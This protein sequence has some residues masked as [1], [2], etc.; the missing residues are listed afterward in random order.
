MKKTIIL[1]FLSLFTYGAIHA[2]VTWK[3][4]GDGTLTISGTEMD[5][6]EASGAPWSFQYKKIKKVVI[7]DGV[8]NIGENAFYFCEN[9]TSVTIPNSVVNIGNS[10]FLYC[11]SLASI[12]IPNSVTTIGKWAFYGCSSL[13]SITIPKSVTTIG[14]NVFIYCKN[15]NSIK[16]EQG[17][18]RYDSRNDCNAIIETKYN[19]LIAGC[20][21]T[22]IPNSVTIV[23][24][25]AFVG[26]S[27]LTSITIP[28]SVTNIAG[29]AF[30]KC[31][32]L[33]SIKVE[34]GNVKYDSRNDCNA[35]IETKSNTL[36][37]GCKNTIIPNSV[38]S[39][40]G[41]AFDGCTDLTSITIPNSVKSIGS[42]AFNECTNLASI[43]IPK[44]VINIGDCAFQKCLG[45]TSIN[46]E[47]GNARY[48]SRNDCNAIIETETNT[49]IL[50]CKN[51]IIPNNVKGIGQ[52]AFWGCPELTSILIPN[53]V[54]VIEPGAF[55]SC[56]NLSSVS[57]PNSVIS[58]G[59]S[60]FY[61]CVSLFSFTLPSSVQSIGP[62][63]FL[64]SIRLKN[65]TCYATTPPS[66]GEG[67]FRG[68]QCENGILYVPASSVSAYQNASGWQEWGQILP[69]EDNAATSIDGIVNGQ[70]C[71][72]KIYN[73]NGQRINGY[74]THKGIY[75]KKGKKYTR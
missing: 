61:G 31:S 55:S 34:E 75:I 2:D 22:V 62:N 7:K 3:L 74:D 51:T 19:R 72:E 1:F 60:A 15:L 47:K 73:Q 46:V 54:T 32:G 59:Q 53:S 5:D 39:I 45:L 70:P 35:I 26:L 23:W 18:A 24:P 44:S 10:A 67:A 4:S 42:L 36:I 25:G 43:T 69:I 33:A 68:T 57:I 6:Y 37:S 63:A 56:R 20:N 52:N 8:T 40:L 12:T 16:V 71:D 11:S 58:I 50:G 48:D 9:I 41:S 21:N 64:S 30:S 49:L 65:M 17:N 13:T 66:V 38:T 28:K 14:D 27:N 29:N